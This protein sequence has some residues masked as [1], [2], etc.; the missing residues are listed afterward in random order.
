MYLVVGLGNPGREYEDTRHNVGFKVIDCLSEKLGFEMSKERFKSLFGEYIL[1]GEKVIF[2]KPLTY[3]NLSGES[4]IEAIMFYKMPLENIIIVYDDMAINVGR[5]RIRN[6]GSH[7]GHNGMKSI[8]NHLKSEDFSRIRIG[9]GSTENNIVDH[10]LGN[11]SKEEDK[12]I[13]KSV[14]TGADSVISIIKD[15]I[16]TSMNKYN[17][18]NANI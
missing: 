10:V 8:I 16:I 12:L 3:M 13:Q 11:F 4:V 15:G 1:E 5:I 7:G 9:I 6:S 2:L 14:N 17:G 18:F